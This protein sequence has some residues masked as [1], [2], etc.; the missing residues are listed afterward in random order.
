MF[1]LGSFFSILQ[2]NMQLFITDFAI[3]HAQVI[4]KNQEIMNQIRKVLRMRIGDSFF[5]QKILGEDI[6][7]YQV[8]IKVRD[9]K[10]I[11]CDILS[12]ATETLRLHTCNQ[13]MIIAMPNKWSKAEII[14]QKLAEIGIQH[15]VFW[16]AQRSIIKDKN[17]NKRSRLQKIIREAT[18]QSWNWVL[19]ELSF[20]TDISTYLQDKK[21]VILDKSEKS[22]DAVLQSFSPD[23]AV[24]GPEGGL[25]DKDYTDI[26]DSH[27]ASL[28]ESI[29]RMETAAIIGGWRMR[30]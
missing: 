12:Q 29:L 11:F 22:I 5:V 16:P 14:V 19:P 20:V 25:T 15:I 2:K 24:V 28:G 10:E 7:R 1:L 3:Q 21:V 30:N 27:I 13:T 6:L 9:N 17:T 4:L 8:Q 26:G 18:E 23:I